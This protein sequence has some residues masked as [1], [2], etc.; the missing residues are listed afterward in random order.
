MHEIGE[1]ED[2]AERYAIAT[3]DLS[4]F[5]TEI[6]RFTVMFLLKRLPFGAMPDFQ[7][8]RYVKIKSLRFPSKIRDNSM[9]VF[10]MV[11]IAN[12]L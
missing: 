3:R 6:H 12:N 1:M 2:S 4:L 9:W 5:D 8:H 11:D 7:T 10:R